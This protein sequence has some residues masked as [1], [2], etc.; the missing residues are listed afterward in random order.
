MVE[1]PV[2]SIRI[3]R[4]IAYLLLVGPRAD[5]TPGVLEGRFRGRRATGDAPDQADQGRR[6]KRTQEG[7]RARGRRYAPVWHVSQTCGGRGTGPLKL[8]LLAHEAVHLAAVGAALGLAHHE[9]DD[10]ADRLRL[11]A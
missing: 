2:W 3:R 6:A 1:W 9:A 7:S 4:D 8:Q 10:G 11:A 5:D